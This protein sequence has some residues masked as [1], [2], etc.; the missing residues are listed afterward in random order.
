MTKLPRGLSERK[1]RRALERAGFYHN[2]QKGRHMVLRRDEPF[3]QVLGGLSGN[4]HAE[5]HRMGC[6]A[7]GGAALGRVLAASP[8]RA[9]HG[10]ST[11]PARYPELLAD[12]LAE[13]VGDFG[14]PGDWSTPSVPR[15]GVEIMALAVSF[16][17]AAGGSQL[18]EESLTF[19][20]ASDRGRRRTPF[21]RTGC[22]SFS[23]RR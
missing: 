4:G 16:E 21:R 1:V 15:V 10:L 14:V 2:R 9:S 6:R 17:H 23:T 12:H 5:A 18:A 20:T 22:W 3:A 7:G 19:H 11:V 13:R 8:W